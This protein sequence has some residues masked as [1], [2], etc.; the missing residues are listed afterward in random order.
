MPPGGRSASCGVAWR[1]GPAAW[2]LRP[3]PPSTLAPRLRAQ[4]LPQP[5]LRV[6]SSERLGELIGRLTEGLLGRSGQTPSSAPPSSRQTSR[7]SP[8][9]LD[10]RSCN[11]CSAR[12]ATTTG[13]SRP[14]FAGSRRNCAGARQSSPSCAGE[15]RGA[16]HDALTDPLTGL[17][18]RRAFDLELGAVERAPEQVVTRA[19]R[20]RRYRSLQAG[21][22]RPWPRHRRRGPA[23]RRRGAARQ[24]Q[25]RQP[26]RAARR[27]RVRA[28]AAGGRARPMRSRSP[29][30]CAR[31]SPPAPSSCAAT[32]RSASGSRSRSGWPVG[33][34]STAVPDGM[35]APTRRSTGRSEAAATRVALDREQQTASVALPPEASGAALTA[36]TNRG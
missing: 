6:P 28:P 10:P 34:R 5:D 1:I 4:R 29:S 11:G 7:A 14:R 8:Y 23:H 30:A 13:A 33:R 26:G 32:P 19:P 24:G 20:D 15:L 16:V 35:P 12:A 3:D 18:N 9:P 2:S 31:P 21:Q 25:A 36:A 27:G 22:R 17:A